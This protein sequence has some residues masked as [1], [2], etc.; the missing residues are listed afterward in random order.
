M[1][2]IILLALN[3][4]LLLESFNEI[5]LKIPGNKLIRNGYIK[6]IPKLINV[7]SI[8]YFCVF[9]NTAPKEDKWYQQNKRNTIPII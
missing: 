4:Q 5:I 7:F 6:E 1:H 2:W 8:R 9:W 3:M